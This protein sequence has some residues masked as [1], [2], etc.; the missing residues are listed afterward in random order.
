MNDKQLSYK[1]LLWLKVKKFF[2]QPSVNQWLVE[3]FNAVEDFLNCSK[4]QLIEKGWPQELISPWQALKC[5]KVNA[6]EIQNQDFKAV[7]IEDEHYPPLLKAIKNPP[8]LLFYKG[9]FSY[10]LSKTVSIVGSRRCSLSGIEFTKKIARHLASNGYT[11]VSGLAYGIDTAAHQGAIEAGTTAAI[12]GC[13]LNIC[14]PTSN[15]ALFSAV[16]AKGCLVSEYFWGERPLKHHFPYRNRIISGLSETLIVIEAGEKSG[17]LITAGFALNQG[18]EVLAAPGNPGE[19]Y[20]KGCNGLIKDGAFLIN[21]IAD[22]EQFFDIKKRA[23][24]NSRKTA[25]NDP[26]L[27][28][29]DEEPKSLDQLAGAIKEEAGALLARLTK[30]EIEQVIAKNE[31]NK[32]FIKT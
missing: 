1:A 11:V 13:G 17:A 18:R 3:N 7:C 9:D 32:F 25:L 5:F 19:I 23:Q 6:K 22:L 24:N 8:A 29:L 10:L 27:N 16:K 31:E 14:F 12:L 21:E 4:G 2:P 20:A 28:L 30:L 26:I 15:T